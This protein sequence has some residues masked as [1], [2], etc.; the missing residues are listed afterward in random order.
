MNGI[1]PGKVGL[2]KRIFNHDI[3]DLTGCLTGNVF[4]GA[5]VRKHP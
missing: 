5:G 3:I 1:T 2:A 4:C